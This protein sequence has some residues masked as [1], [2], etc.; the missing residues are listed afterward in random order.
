MISSFLPTS[1]PSTTPL[2]RALT[3]AL[4]A[5][6]SWALARAMRFFMPQPSTYSS[7][8][9]KDVNIFLSSVHRA[10]A[11]GLTR[12]LYPLSPEK[13]TTFPQKYAPEIQTFYALNRARTRLRSSAHWFSM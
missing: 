7:S 5:G 11:L 6:S 4:N 12:S 3:T 8:S 9:L 13:T 2:R 10:A 1:V